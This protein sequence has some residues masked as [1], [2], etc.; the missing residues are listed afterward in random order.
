MREIENAE[1]GALGRV[2]SGT[3]LA[4]IWNGLLQLCD[5]LSTFAEVRGLIPP[6]SAYRSRLVGIEATNGPRD[7][8]RHEAHGCQLRAPAAGG[9][10]RACALDGS[11]RRAEPSRPHGIPGRDGHPIPTIAQIGLAKNSFARA[12]EVLLVE[13]LA[14][15]CRDELITAL[16]I[17]PAP[18]RPPPAPRVGG[19]A[20]VLQPRTGKTAN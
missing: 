18:Q 5:D 13:P 1:V 17:G 8:H 16:Q 11:V 15:S 4:R 7:A 12:A 20:S 6:V 19:T 3:D 9:L 14:G 2:G 10:D